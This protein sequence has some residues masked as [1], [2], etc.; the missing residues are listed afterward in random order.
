MLNSPILF[1]LIINKISGDNVSVMYFKLLTHFSDHMFTEDR[2]IHIVLK[3][4]KAIQG[5]LLYNLKLGE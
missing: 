2:I 1:D 5:Y 3:M 4:I